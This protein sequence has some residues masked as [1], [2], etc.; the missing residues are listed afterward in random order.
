MA[1][2]LGAV[3]AYQIYRNQKADNKKNF[4]EAE[5]RKT[6]IW[7]PLEIVGDQAFEFL[8]DKIKK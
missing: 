6:N 8:F 5:P 3:I 7:T 4:Y 1:A 2:I